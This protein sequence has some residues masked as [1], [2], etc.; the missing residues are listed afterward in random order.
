M[1]GVDAL[2]ALGKTQETQRIPVIANVDAEP[3]RDAGAITIATTASRLA[4]IAI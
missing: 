1:S 4:S 3:K 2:H